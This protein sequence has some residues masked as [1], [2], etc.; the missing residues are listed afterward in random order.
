MNKRENDRRRRRKQVIYKGN[1]KH[2]EDDRALGYTS[3]DS[4]WIREETVTYNG[5]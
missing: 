3:I 4:V 2:R 1:E 5:N